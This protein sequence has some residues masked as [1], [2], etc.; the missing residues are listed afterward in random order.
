MLIGLIRF[1]Q[2]KWSDLTK[3]HHKSLW[4]WDRTR[5]MLSKV[6]QPISIFQRYPWIHH[7]GARLYVYPCPVIASTKVRM[8]SVPQHSPRSKGNIW[9]VLVPRSLYDSHSESQLRSSVGHLRTL[10]LSMWFDAMHSKQV[11]L[12]LTSYTMRMRSNTRQNDYIA[13]RPL[14]AINGRNFNIHHRV[15]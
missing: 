13:F 12:D 2:T 4:S 6:H 1:S 3:Q 10:D 8:Y 5:R 15:V 9:R 11:T 7:L 14:K